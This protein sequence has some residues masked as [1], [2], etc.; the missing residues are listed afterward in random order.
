MSVF[1]KFL[2]RRC[3]IPRPPVVV[4]PR[5][6]PQSHV[7]PVPPQQRRHGHTTTQIPLILSHTWGPGRG[8]ISRRPPQLLAP[9]A[10]R[11][12]SSAQQT[13]SSTDH[14]SS[15]SP[16]ADNK[17]E[18]QL[19]A[20]LENARE[21]FAGRRF[22]QSLEANQKII[23]RS[24]S[25][26]PEQTEKFWIKLCAA[27]I[28]GAFVCK[29]LTDFDRGVELARAGVRQ[30]ERRFSKHKQQTAEANE[31]LAEVLLLRSTHEELRGAAE[32]EGSKTSSAAVRS[33]DEAAEAIERSLE[34]KRSYLPEF[35]PAF[36]TPYNI[37]GRVCE[38]RMELDQAQNH[39]LSAFR[40]GFLR[41]HLV[42]PAACASLSNYASL[43]QEKGEYEIAIG[44]YEKV[45][46]FYQDWGKAMVSG[47]GAAGV[48][49]GG[50][51]AGSVDASGAGGGAG[52]GVYN[53]DNDLTVGQAFA[54]L[55]VAAF[56]A[57]LKVRATES[58]QRALSAHVTVLGME[59][60]GTNNILSL[61]MQVRRME[62]TKT[63][64][65]QKQEKVEIG[66]K[67]VEELVAKQRKD[68]DFRNARVRDMTKGVGNVVGGES[69]YFDHAGHVG[70]GP[71]GDSV[72]YRAE[73]YFLPD[74][75][76][77][78]AEREDGGG[79]GKE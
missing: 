41:G 61:L 43:L 79:Q 19:D 57:G 51:S 20:L 70:H 4:S 17:L 54:E 39:Y 5:P 60:P 24:H 59:H 22:E 62:E 37:Y 64:A 18:Q 73:K 38:R 46:D 47:A 74:E 69:T 49:V 10:T 3:P 45:C 2:A 63:S 25:W 66:H 53:P 52:P 29:M 6:A 28:N 14:C 78:K 9:A 72:R 40:H 34:I 67:F 32:E 8:G 68:N 13:R 7:G 36:A 56:G 12:A 35:D 48:A 11:T 76:Y 21:A 42:P 65:D 26:T 31:L 30:F 55:G 23:D 71:R 77:E 27:Q 50:A 1:S 16:D 33:I 15:D 58:L 44:I 75:V